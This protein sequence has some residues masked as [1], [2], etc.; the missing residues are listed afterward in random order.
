MPPTC[1][2]RTVTGLGAAVAAAEALAAAG[3]LPGAVAGPPPQAAR[4]STVA[5]SAASFFIPFRRRWRALRSPFGAGVAGESRAAAMLGRGR[6]RG[7]GPGIA[8]PPGA[9]AGPRPG[10]SDGVGQA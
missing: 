7:E 9:A 6:L 10:R 2:K 1:P 4:T 3:A 5:A 8:A